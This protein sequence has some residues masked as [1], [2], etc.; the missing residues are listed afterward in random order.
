MQSRYLKLLNLPKVYSDESIVGYKAAYLYQRVDSSNLDLFFVGL[1]GQEEYLV[2]SNAVCGKGGKHTSPEITCYCGFY[3]FKNK[4]SAQNALLVRGANVL[5]T[6]EAYGD[7][8]E[9]EFGYRAEEQV[10]MR[11][12]VGPVCRICGSTADGMIEKNAY[13]TKILAS[14]CTLCA[15]RENVKLHHLIDIANNLGTEVTFAPRVYRVGY[16]Y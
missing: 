2:D 6:V 4:E 3:M 12:E 15:K 9:H 1:R 11:V 8:I 16:W 10:V 5:L 14:C 13:D 7:I